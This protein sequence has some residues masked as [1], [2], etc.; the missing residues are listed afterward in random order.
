MIRSGFLGKKGFWLNATAIVLPVMG[1]EIK[2]PYYYS[3]RRQSFDDMPV[4][5]F[6]FLNAL[7]PFCDPALVAN[8]EQLEFPLEHSKGFESQPVENDIIWICYKPLVV[9]EGAVPVKENG[10]LRL[11]G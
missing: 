5:S 11:H 8:D 7:P 1:T 6:C 9:N 2:I 4:D 10:V 3:F